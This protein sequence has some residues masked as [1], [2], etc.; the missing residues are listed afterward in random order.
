MAITQARA[1]LAPM[2]QENRP[3]YYRNSVI[4]LEIKEARNKGRL[5]FSINFQGRS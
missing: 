4:L 5:Y 3:N 1:G 2:L